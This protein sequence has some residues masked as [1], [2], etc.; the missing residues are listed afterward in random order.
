[1]SSNPLVA[2][3]FLSLFHVIGGSALGWSLRQFLARQFGCM[4]WFFIV[5]GGMFGLLPLIVGTAIFSQMHL[6]YLVGA[7]VVVLAAAIAIAAFVPPDFL[8]SFS[9]SNFIMLGLGG[10]F[11]LIG[12][13]IFAF[14][15]TRNLNT[16]LPASAIVIFVGGVFFVLGIIYAL[17]NRGN[18]L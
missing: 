5:W 15:G 3:I 14:G 12:S 4:T 2:I 8:Q 16:S 11:V 9:S 18:P 6:T 10:L 13:A 7:Q 17:R 1:M